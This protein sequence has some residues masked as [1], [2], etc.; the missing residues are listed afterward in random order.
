M[1]K[2]NTTA[3]AI[4]K[5]PRAVAAADS[6]SVM[7]MI[8]TASK[9]KTVDVGKM[10]RLVELFERI[11]KTEQKE[12]YAAAMVKLKPLLPVIDR[13]GRIVVRAKDAHGNRTGAVQQDTP[14]ALWEDI[15]EAITPVLHD[16]GFA[17]TFRTGNEADGRLRVTAVLQHERGHFE[18]TTMALPFDT[19]GSKNNVQAI[20]SSTS[21]GKRYT[22][23]AILNIRTRGEDDDGIKGGD[24]SPDKITKV[25]RD[26]LIQRCADAK[27]SKANFCTAFSIA[28]VGDLPA[29]KLTDAINRI[30]GHKKKYERKPADAQV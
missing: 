13:R 24:I 10:E 16:C 19:S 23:C 3:I 17:L 22:A 14:Y 5:P 9:D 12:A 15:D 11:K 29:A 28:E 20:G 30:D 27:I 21:Y 4:H 6:S 26:D 18:E 7:A 25:Q 1:A 2:K 8:G